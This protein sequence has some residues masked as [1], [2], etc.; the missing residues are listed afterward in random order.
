MNEL[1]KKKDSDWTA[2]DRFREYVRPT[3]C[4]VAYPLGW[5]CRQ[6][7]SDHCVKHVRPMTA[8]YWVAGWCQLKIKF[9]LSYLCSN[10][11]SFIMPINI[12]LLTDIMLNVAKVNKNLWS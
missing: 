10:H 2:G 3:S 1:L 6:P 4:R 8:H 7:I 12:F 5:R 9:V 11:L